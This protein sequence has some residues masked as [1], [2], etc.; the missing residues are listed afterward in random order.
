VASLDTN[1]DSGEAIASGSGA[2]FFAADVSDKPSVDSAFAA[3]VARLGGLDVLIH[4]AGIAPA[5]PS[6]STPVTL[7]ND[8]MRIN[9]TGTMLANQA[10]VPYL[11]G[12]GGAILNFASA[13]G[14]QGLANKAAY[15]ASKGA[16]LAWTRTVAREWARY[17]ITV[18][19]VVP[20]IWTAMYDKTRSELTPQQLAAHDAQMAHIV[21]L[22]GRL[23]DVETDF[24]PVMAFY[25]SAGAHFLT[26]Q[27]LA[28]DGGMTMIG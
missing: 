9:A 26:G 15:A 16:V 7:W 4:A 11:K 14:V 6:E 24:V 21:P 3:A 8:I 17:R 10:A 19:A 23:G 1:E 5:C 18:N 2:A 28:I 12:A 27:T 22:G 20:G 13:A 25:A